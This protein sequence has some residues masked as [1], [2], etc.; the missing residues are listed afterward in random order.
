MSDSRVLETAES[1]RVLSKWRMV[2]QQVEDAGNDGAS[3]GTGRV[4]DD[5]NDGVSEGAELV[6]EP[7]M[8]MQ[9]YLV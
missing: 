9:M 8:Q 3:K 6:E 4:E 1:T 5:G 2:T 7:V